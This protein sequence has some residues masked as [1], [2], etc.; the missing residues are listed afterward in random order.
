M[1]DQAFSLLVERL[2]GPSAS[3]AEAHDRAAMDAAWQRLFSDYYRRLVGLAQKLLRG[4]AAH[5]SPDSAV[6]SAFRSFYVRHAQG[7]FP[8]LPCGVCWPP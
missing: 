3:A 7:G 5:T 1:P 2:V 4:L 8:E 6:L